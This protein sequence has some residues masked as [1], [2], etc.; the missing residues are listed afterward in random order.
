[1]VSWGRCV[2]DIIKLNKRPD[3]VPIALETKICGIKAWTRTKQCWTARLKEVLYLDE[4]ILLDD[5]FPVCTRISLTCREQSLSVAFNQSQSATMGL[6][7]V[8]GHGAMLSGPCILS[9]TDIL[10]GVRTVS[11]SQNRVMRIMA[12]FWFWKVPKKSGDPWK[13]LGTTVVEGLWLMTWE[14]YPL[15]NKVLVF[16]IEVSD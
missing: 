13:S 7:E 8:S 16:G 2:V 9:W 5:V 1:M 4:Y 3:W 11:L 14:S 6:N 10:A 15:W 12:V